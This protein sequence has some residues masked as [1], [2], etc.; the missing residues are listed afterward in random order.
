MSANIAVNKQ[1]EV[2]VVRSRLYTVQISPT[3]WGLH[4]SLYNPDVSVVYLFTSSLRCL[5]VYI[6]RMEVGSGRDELRW[7]MIHPDW[8]RWR[9][10]VTA[11]SRTVAANKVTSR[12][13]CDSYCQCGGSG[14]DDNVKS[15]SSCEDIVNL[16]K[17]QMKHY[18][19]ASARH[20]VVV[21]VDRSVEAEAPSWPSRRRVDESPVSVH[22]HRHRKE[23]Q[24]QSH[25]HHSCPVCHLG[26]HSTDNVV[27][28]TW[29][30]PLYSVQPS[31]ICL[32]SVRHFLFTQHCVRVS[33][34]LPVTVRKKDVYW[35]RSCCLMTKS[36]CCRSTPSLCPPLYHSTALPI[37]SV[38]A[39]GR[40][41][42]LVECMS[43]SH[44]DVCVAVVV[45]DPPSGNFMPW[46]GKVG[47]WNTGGRGKVGMGLLV[48][49]CCL[50]TV[51]WCQSDN[52]TNKSPLETSQVLCAG[53]T[54][55]DCVP[56]PQLWE[57]VQP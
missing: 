34:Q 24:D 41:P 47:V 39:R 35:H 31:K 13:P 18:I 30:E 17:E 9:T 2:I 20:F 57:K 6:S 42:D 19:E 1:K 37:G 56:C 15:M 10:T 23:R 3:G 25:R 45:W 8:G 54:R 51:G 55:E 21:V 46:E 29:T 48:G 5:L 14:D 22:H 32:V 38:D 36:R 53:M 43:S 44:G 52:T 40:D 11:E 7:E 28:Y 33:W 49:H 50:W 4:S 26:H 27:V 12:P 16:S